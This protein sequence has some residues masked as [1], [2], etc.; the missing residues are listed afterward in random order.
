MDTYDV[1]VIGGGPAGENLAGRVAEE[2]FTVAL[3]ERELVGGECSYWGCIP[4]KTLLRPGEAL[5]AVRRVPG[6]RAA[7][8]GTID[9]AE[10]LARR[11]FMTSN[12]DDASQSRWLSNE[13]I[14]LVRGT[15][16][17]VGARAVDV[18]DADGT[19]THLEARRAVGLATGTSAAV[20]PIPGLRDIRIWDN[21]GATAADD[22]PRR[23]LVLGGGVIGV[24]MG[25]AFSR[26]G[27]EEVTIVEKAER[28]VANEE[29][30][31][32][33]ELR[34]AFEAEGIDVVVGVG[35]AAVRRETDDGPV[36]G[37]LDDGREIEADEI[38]VAVGR[39]PN[40]GD[41]GLE[42]VGIE[43]G[44]SVT[45]DDQ[46]RVV[47]VEG[48]WLYAIGDINGRALLTHMAKYQ[49]RIASDVIVGKPGE[50][51][52]DHRAIPRV[53]FTDPQVAAVGLT[54]RQAREQYRKLRVLT[55]GTGD[56]S[57]ASVMGEG[58]SGTSQL[59]VDESRRV[60]VGATFTG[61]AVAEMLQSATIAI[62]GEVP[63][64]VLWHAVPAFPTVS[65]VWLRLLEAYGL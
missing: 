50:A 61:Y 48:G 3:V 30:F 40:S 23:L 2:G 15:G 31:A 12:W 42:A 5:A 62:A 34:A 24:E 35:I 27:A 32:G 53:T 14:V 57:G 39:R 64:D 45:V 54:E 8:T 56:V 19:V 1:I 59:V 47:G 52:A 41:L 63:L 28:L 13:G 20:P 51:W 58:L 29:P 26:L 43:A 22:I 33:E 60:V 49:A 10:V 16:R 21:R 4:S 9:V 18:T 44:R 17:L 55:Y 36:V 6:A 11:N 25:Q 65:E 37:T 38:L 7:V 46:L